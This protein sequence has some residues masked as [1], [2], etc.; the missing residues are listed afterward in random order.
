M[1]EKNKLK[2]NNMRIFIISFIVIIIIL[3]IVSNLLINDIEDYYYNLI[4]MESVKLAK[5][6]SNALT[7][8]SQAH[9]RVNELLE[10][11]ILAAGK[12]VALYDG[13][14]SDESVKE[15][16][17]SLEVDDI[18]IYNSQGEIIFSSK[19]N[20]IGWKAYKGHPI[21]DFINGDT[22]SLVGETRKD[23][24][25]GDYYRYEYFERSNGGFIQ[26]GVLADKMESFLEGFEIQEILDQLDDG[27]VKQISF[28]DNDLNVVES[29]ESRLIGIQIED[30]KVKSEINEN[31]ESSLVDEY[32]GESIYQVFVPVYS[33]GE[34][35]GT[36]AVGQ[37]LKETDAIIRQLS[38]MGI[39]TLLIIIVLL[40]YGFFSTYNKNIK[41]VKLLYY[42]VLTG[43]PNK[44][45][46]EKHLE[47]EI[48]K[49][50]EKKKAIFLI[51]LRDFKTVNSTYGFQ[52]GD[53]VLKETADKL[54]RAT[55]LYGKLFRFT[56]DRFV[57]YVDY[58]KSREKLFF[59][60]D[61]INR[62]F[63]DSDE[64]AIGNLFPGIEI[65]IIE[66]NNK[67]K[68]V[69]KIFKNASLSLD[70]MEPSDFINYVFY[71]EEMQ[72][73]FER[74][75]IIEKEII[76][77]LSEQDTNTM[78]L[79]YQPQVD[80]KTN[81]IIGFEALARMK[82]EI[83]GFVSPIEFIDIVERKQLIVPLGIWILRTACNFIHKLSSE[84]YK[85]IKVSVNIS[86]LQLLR[87]DFTETVIDII[88]ETGIQGTNLVLEITESVVLDASDVIKNRLKKLRDLG[89]EIALD[90]FGTGYSSLS[91]IRQLNVDYVKIDKEFID[92][93][94]TIS[95]DELITEEIISMCHKLGFI[96]VAE[97]V[98]VEEQ[99]KYLIEKKCDIMQ[100]YLFSKPLDEDIALE[101][102]KG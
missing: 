47:E 52:Y 22:N 84:G 13:G 96:V 99:K 70:Y 69:D 64:S 56:S 7:T 66:I 25:I 81:K 75:E 18:Y 51:N 97:G 46:L 88:K 44:L 32:D 91:R 85:D 45:Y 53:N 41:L 48:E 42:D 100:G 87:D 2:V 62:V 63:R 72:E 83:L 19:G 10:E 57:L 76:T 59:L 43:L 37:S 73:R 40:F 60:V 20:F 35:V 86:G 79:Q 67:Y 34:K 98:E 17:E 23:L 65:G 12:M 28:L 78:F 16:A 39:L 21:Y 54:N 5:S 94:R 27:V 92:K 49:I 4:E 1:S 3:A 33:K 30:E 77:V 29:T 68:D 101:I 82:T 31:K 50:N 11:K 89:I 8:A 55:H 58:Y 26:V 38:G 24:E 36:L 14:Y 74:E 6:Y 61:K 15:L 9:E 80:L 102:L 95:K 71:D 93:I 90:D